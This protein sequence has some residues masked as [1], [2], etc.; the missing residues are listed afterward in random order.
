VSLEAR[1]IN[2]VRA[3]EGLG[4]EALREAW[5]RRGYGAPPR[6]RSAPLLALM[7]A[8]RIQADALGGLDADL[9]R[10]LRRGV[11][12][13]TA[14]IALPG[15]ARLSREWKGEVHEVEVT[16]DGF[17]YRDQVYP[18]LSRIAR[19]ITGVRWNGRRFF[20]LAK[21]DAG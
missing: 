17:R 10:R 8:Y 15:G 3:L 5:R 7:L 20:G 1:I 18:S 16:G 12:L 13:K 9:A 19:E 21:D 11:G 2:E 6:L 14:A 4:L